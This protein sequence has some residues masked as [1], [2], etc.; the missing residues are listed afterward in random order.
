MTNGGQHDPF[1]RVARIAKLMSLHRST[2]YAHIAKGLWPPMLPMG[3]NRAGMWE[4]ELKRMQAV[5]TQPHT[6]E[7][8]RETVQSIV[9]GR[10]EHARAMQ[11]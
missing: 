1:L 10:K 9:Q 4:S 6:E 11:G 5:L 8:V 2:L 3:R 7:E